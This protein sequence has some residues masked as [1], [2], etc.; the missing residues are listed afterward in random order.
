MV[1]K[2]MGNPPRHVFSLQSDA[3][4]PESFTNQELSSAFVPTQDSMRLES[5]Q[6]KN[7]DELWDELFYEDAL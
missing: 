2:E 3:L 1:A 4:G 7:S 5:V 6:S